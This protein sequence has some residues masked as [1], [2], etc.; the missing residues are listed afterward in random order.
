MMGMKFLVPVSLIG[1]ALSGCV[2][3]PLP[4]G[5]IAPTE[6]SAYRLGPGDKLR[7]TTFNEPNLSGEFVIAGSGSLAMPLAGDI[8]ARGLTPDELQK[9]IAARLEA[10]GF[11]RSP[12]VSA[13]V[14]EYRPY[15]ILGEVTK[16]G[17]Y[18][19]TI[20]LTVSKAVA[21]AGGFSYRAN[22]RKVL[23]TRDGS[24]EEVEVQLTASTPIGPGDTIRIAERY[25]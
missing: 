19:F 13:E 3:A 5:T 7:V 1:A 6:A 18:P 11:V 4:P 25:F 9:A 2:T 15:Y 24:T 12:Q 14:I 21:T 22:Q 23:I 16:P 8:P 17:Q 10:G 20:G